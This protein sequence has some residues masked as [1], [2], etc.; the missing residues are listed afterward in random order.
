MLN[1]AEFR[2]RKEAGCDDYLMRAHAAVC[3]RCG[4]YNQLADWT[5]ALL[6]NSLLTPEAPPTW[7]VLAA[8]HQQR[9]AE[10]KKARRRKRSRDATRRLMPYI[11]AVIMFLMMASAVGTR[12]SASVQ[13]S[14]ANAVNVTK[15]DTMLVTE[16]EVPGTQN[17]PADA[18]AGDR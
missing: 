1:C 10:E 7:S 14:N 11:A 16:A 9:L 18:F 3:Q 6:N 5:R 13:A 17:T 8:I 2:A 4:E 15:A 12:F